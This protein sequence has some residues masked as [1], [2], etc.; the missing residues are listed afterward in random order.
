VKLGKKVSILWTKWNR[1]VVDK[2]AAHWLNRHHLRLE[3][4]RFYQ[5]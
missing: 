2:T 1:V 5:V 4:I 3:L